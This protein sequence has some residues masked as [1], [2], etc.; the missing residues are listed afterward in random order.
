MFV[1]NHFP[2]I[3]AAS[4][5]LMENQEVMKAEMNRLRRQV[6]GSCGPEGTIDPFTK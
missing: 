2:P 6:I 5:R 4:A 1:S 3:D